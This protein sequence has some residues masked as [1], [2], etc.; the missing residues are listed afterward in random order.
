MNGM[1][2][3][4]LNVGR[5]L[6]PID[7]PQGQL[8]SSGFLGDPSHAVGRLREIQ[9]IV[10]LGLSLALV[11]PALADLPADDADRLARC[12]AL[13]DV[14]N[15][16]ACYESTVQ[17]TEAKLYHKLCGQEIAAFSASNDGVDPLKGHGELGVYD[18]ETLAVKQMDFAWWSYREDIG[19]QYGVMMGGTPM[20]PPKDDDY[21]SWGR[22]APGDA[23][24]RRYEDGQ[25]RQLVHAQAAEEELCATGASEAALETPLGAMLREIMQ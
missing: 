14:A 16:L 2:L 12:L 6:A 4:E 19:H 22:A 25:Y 13:V 11:T 24:V 15:R 7:D 10:F 23:R 8:D 5:L 3:A 18:P 9:A 21:L 20:P 1:H 17:K